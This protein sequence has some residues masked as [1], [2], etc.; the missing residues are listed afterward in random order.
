M[1]PSSGL[2]RFLTVIVDYCKG[3]V[4]TNNSSAQCC[5]DLFNKFHHKVT[6]QVVLLATG[7]GLPM[8][9]FYNPR[10]A[11]EIILGTKQDHTTL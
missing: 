4:S 1:E 7:P 11:T 5:V 2:S 9:V 8:M 10:H 3:E 6:T